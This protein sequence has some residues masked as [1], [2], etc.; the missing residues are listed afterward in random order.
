ML[1]YCIVIAGLIHLKEGRLPLFL[2]PVFIE[3]YLT[4]VGGKYQSPVIESFLK[5]I[6]H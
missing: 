1:N 4:L 6:A 3:G 2:C 5:D